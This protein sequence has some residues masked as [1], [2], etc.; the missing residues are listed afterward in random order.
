MRLLA[1]MGIFVRFLTLVAASIALS[2]CSSDGGAAITHTYELG[3][4]AQVG[5][6]GYTV[7]ERQ[8]MNQLGEPG[9]ADA[10]IPTNRFLLLRISVLNSGGSDASVP[11][12]KLLDD[13]GKT[14]DETTNGDQAPQYIGAVRQVKPADTLQG[15][16]LFD[17]PPQHYKIVVTDEDGKETAYVDLPLS[18]DAATS[19]VPQAAPPKK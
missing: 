1:L 15:N 4:K 11:N 9:S 19:D 6:L 3:T 14:W 7:F 18:F 16:V 17:A 12:L 10:R 5:T 8:W 13:K 2:S